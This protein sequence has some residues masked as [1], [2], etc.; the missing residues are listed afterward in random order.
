[1]IKPEPDCKFEPGG[2]SEWIHKYINAK[3]TEVEGLLA[4]LDLNWFRIW[5]QSLLDELRNHFEP[6]LM[7]MDPGGEDW[8]FIIDNKWNRI[9]IIL[10]QLGLYK[11]A[12]LLFRK[13]YT[14]LCHLQSSRGRVHKGTPLYQIGWVELVE[15]TRESVARSKYFMKLALIE[16]YLSAPDK[17]TV[18]PA[19]RN[20]RS[21]H[22]IDDHVLDKFVHSI[23]AW[24]KN[25]HSPFEKSRP[26]LIYLDIVRDSGN[27]EESD[28]FHFN[29]D[30][31][32]YLLQSLKGAKNA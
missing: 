28:Y 12:R 2:F 11:W 26:E 23:T 6:R 24:L 10:A 5:T 9:G 13:E 15:G 22:Y 3:P 32:M 18:L 1:M 7:K 30:I 16:D 8:K 21:E 19:F 27:S 20:L 4:K 31:A 14:A 29:P 25:E 17:H